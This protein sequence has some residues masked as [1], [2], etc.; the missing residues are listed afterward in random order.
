M[1]FSFTTGS[2]AEL[3]K[4]N[5]YLST[6]FYIEGL[7]QTQ[8]DV[9]VYRLVP[10]DLDAKTYPHVSRWANHISAFPPRVR[11]RWA[12]GKLSVDDQEEKKAA[13]QDKKSSKK[14]S[15]KPAKKGSDKGEE[16]S[17]KKDSKKGKKDKKKD[18]KNKHK[19]SI[20]EEPAA[21]EVAVE[22]V[23]P[24][25]EEEVAEEPAA[26]E[27]PAT[28]EAAAEDAPEDDGN[29][30]FDDLG[31]DNNEDDDDEET[32]AMFAKQK[33]LVKS[34]QERQAANATKAKSN[35]T[36][37]VKPYDT[38]TD[39]AELEKKI[40]TIEIEGLKW[41]GGTLIDVAYGIKK[42]RI[43]CQLVDVLVNPD[44][45]REE[46]EKFEEEVQSTDVFAFQM[47]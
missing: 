7:G 33:D 12:K 20:P 31:L 8:N 24:V 44:S 46:I 5:A 35:L 39:M 25:V 28:E 6:R 19:D 22:E 41:L 17:E 2:H 13:P 18:K 36:L 23:A 26:A 29:I 27:E 32:K 45:V 10:R 9:K 42:L 38:E 3:A 40:R 14:G 47:A 16:K 4:L 34:I 30:D 15:D 11:S 1:D 21:E 37:D 43:M